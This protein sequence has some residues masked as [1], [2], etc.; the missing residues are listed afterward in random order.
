MAWSPLAGGLLADGARKLLPSQESYVVAAAHAA[1]DAIAQAHGVTRAV[2]A[3]AWLL[4]HPGGIVPIVGSTNPAS[5]R[6][7]ARADELELTRDEWYRLLVA[8]RGQRLP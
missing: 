3:L 7:A 4:R 8:G 5:I 6:D 2:V 1:L